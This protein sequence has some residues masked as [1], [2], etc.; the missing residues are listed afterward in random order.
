MT[1]FRRLYFAYEGYS[2]TFFIAHKICCP[3]PGSNPRTL[4][5]KANTIATR[6]LDHR[7]R[8]KEDLKRY[9]AYELN[10]DLLVWKH[11]N[12]KSYHA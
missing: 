1:W 2:S 4:D 5:P 10:G 12:R 11:I 8:R 9:Q 6:E 3:R 7:E